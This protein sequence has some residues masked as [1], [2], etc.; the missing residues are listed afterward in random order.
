MLVNVPY[1]VPILGKPTKIAVL[2]ANEASQHICYE[3]VNWQ[4]FV[5]VVCRAVKYLVQPDA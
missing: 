1:S 4:C 5:R 3:L 2:L